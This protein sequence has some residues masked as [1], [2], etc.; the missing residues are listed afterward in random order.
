MCGGSFEGNTNT[1]SSTTDAC[2]DLDFDKF[3]ADS[4]VYP[5]GDWIN[6]EESQEDLEKEWKEGLDEED[7]SQDLRKTEETDEEEEEEEGDEEG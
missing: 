5:E 7:V 2:K 6:E 4:F 1:Q 3:D